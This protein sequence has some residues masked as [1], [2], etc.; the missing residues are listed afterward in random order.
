MDAA[1]AAR[2]L[3]SQAKS[4]SKACARRWGRLLHKA[5]GWQVRTRFAV[6]ATVHNKLRSIGG[7]RA[8]SVRVRVL[9]PW[10]IAAK[11]ARGAAEALEADGVF[12]RPEVLETEWSQ[13]PAGRSLRGWRAC[14]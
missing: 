7:W 5:V 14:K 1:A 10:G 11:A 9:L 2:T 3:E 4:R 13:G 6:L 8:V 12:G